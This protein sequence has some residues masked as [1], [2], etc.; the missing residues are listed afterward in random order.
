MSERL[1]TEHDS[2]LASAAERRRHPRTAVNIPV[3]IWLD[4]G[5]QQAWCCDVSQGGLGVSAF[6]SPQ[7]GTLLHVTLQQPEREVDVQAE[8]VRAGSF[9]T[10][11]VGL[12][13]VGPAPEVV[14]S[15]SRD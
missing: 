5:W 11:L 14:R 1:Q 15:L 2:V 3:R 6:R 4:I 9:P 10:D 8:V 13:W 7:I 12:R